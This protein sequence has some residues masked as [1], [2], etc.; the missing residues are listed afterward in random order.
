MKAKVKRNNNGLSS[1]LIYYEHKTF[2]HKSL[3]RD[4]F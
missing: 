1:L 4:N 2:L 3:K